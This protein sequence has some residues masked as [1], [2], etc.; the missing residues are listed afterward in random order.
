MSYNQVANPPPGQVART[1][2]SQVADPSIDQVAA[3]IHD[4]EAGPSDDNATDSP[5]SYIDV[6]KQFSPSYLP[7]F[8]QDIY[9]VCC[10]LSALFLSIY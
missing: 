4:Q 3:S 5:Q 7:C 8:C 6:P 2:Y 10:T 1:F 9:F